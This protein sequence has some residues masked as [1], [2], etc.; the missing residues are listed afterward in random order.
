MLTVKRKAYKR[1][2]YTRKGG[3]HVKGTSIPKATFKIKDKGK[4]GRTPKSQQFY[5]PKVKTGWESDMP[6]AKRRRLALKGH[7]GDEL[8]TARGLLALSNVQKRINP[9][10]S[11]K[12]RAD[13]DYFFGLNR[14]KKR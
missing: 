11:R 9:E 14:K 5:H 2:P 12:A 4:K 13:A 10:V 6:M 3:V 1:K 8:A 7:K